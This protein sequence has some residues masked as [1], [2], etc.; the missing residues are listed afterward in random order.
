MSETSAQGLEQMH[1]QGH[2]MAMRIA[3]AF[4]DLAE[5]LDI[6]NFNI[7][8][9]NQHVEP[10]SP[11]ANA[12]YDDNGT[13]NSIELDRIS[14]N[15]QYTRL[16][17]D[18]RFEE[19]ACVNIGVG[20]CMDLLFRQIVDRNRRST[21]ITMTMLE[22]L[23]DA[24]KIK[25]ALYAIDDSFKDNSHLHRAAEMMLDEMQAGP[26]RVARI[27]AQR[28][29]FGMCMRADAMY[30]LETGERVAIAVRDD[31]RYQLTRSA[32]AT[33][34]LGMVLTND[35]DISLKVAA[36]T[37]IDA[38][39]L[40]LAIPASNGEL[41]SFLAAIQRANTSPEFF[42][43]RQI[44]ELSDGFTVPVQEEVNPEAGDDEGPR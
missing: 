39:D 5:G 36:D 15:D 12:H 23:S 20:I 27:N 30:D 41:D 4:P 44:E 25:N 17:D 40:A 19:L 21:N 31:I 35:M 42:T 43:I 32:A 38:R 33:A 11:I 3:Q 37:I 16:R 6:G 29:A 34:I 9:S 18:V 10:G 22:H 26:E 28:F 14:L 7:T 24:G 2:Q 13:L 1:R 8:F